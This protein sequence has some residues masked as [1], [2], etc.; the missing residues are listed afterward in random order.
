MTT[1]INLY[2]EQRDL[3]RWLNVRQKFTTSISAERTDSL[4]MQ[5]RPNVIFWLGS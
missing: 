2:L 1:A 3:C 4:N 5:N